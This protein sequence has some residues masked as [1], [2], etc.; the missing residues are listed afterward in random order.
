MPWWLRSERSERLETTCRCL[1][2]RPENVGGV[3]LHGVMATTTDLDSRAGV[4]AAARAARRAETVA[5]ADQLR[6][7]AEWAAMHEVL[8]VH[9]AAASAVFGETV[10]PV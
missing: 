5:A 3:V 1:V 6:W 7:A 2:S 8:D 4:L 10:V 9:D